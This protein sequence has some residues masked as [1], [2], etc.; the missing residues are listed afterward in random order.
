MRRDKILS[1]EV[2]D[3]MKVQFQQIKYCAARD[4][5]KRRAQ[6]CPNPQ[7]VD[8]FKKI[9]TWAVWFNIKFGESLNDYVER[10][11]RDGKP[12]EVLAMADERE[13]MEA[14]KQS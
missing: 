9:V 4:I 6:N 7:R 14:G 3:R 13:R 12:P 5:W 11:K 1:D 2:L 10:I 8:G